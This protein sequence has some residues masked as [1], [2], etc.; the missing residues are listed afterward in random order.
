[1]SK[2]FAVVLFAAGLSVSSLSMAEKASDTAINELLQ[3]L[4]AFTVY[5]A[6]FSQRSVDDSGETMQQLAGTLLLKRPDKF[7]WQADE[8]AAQKLISDGKTIWHL[9]ED[10]A[11]VVV[12]KY[13]EQR[14]QS[15]LLIILEDAAQ[16]RSDY[17]VT[18]VPVQEDAKHAQTAYELKALHSDNPVKVITLGFVNDQL[19]SLIFVD[20][21]QQLT[22]VQFSEVTLNASIDEKVFDFSVPEDVDVLYE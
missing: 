8:P 21:L 2:W 3:R 16:L 12:Q 9:D 19:A 10:L 14:H 20:A 18:I 6:R 22:E 15:P 1:M 5:Q 11:Q 4:A 17:A 7:L 13:A